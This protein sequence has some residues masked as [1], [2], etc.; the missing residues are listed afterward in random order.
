MIQ[1]IQ[2]YQG[3][4][5]SNEITIQQLLAQTSGIPDYYDEKAKDGKT[6]FD[7]FLA[8]PTRIWSVDEEIARA[9]DEMTPGFKPGEKAFYSDTNYQLLGKIIEARTGK[10]LEVVFNELL[11]QPLGLKHTWLVG[12]SQP[13]EK[14]SAGV[15]QVFY[16]EVN[17]T[18]IR[19]TTAYWADGGIVATPE[20]CVTFLKALNQGRIIRKDSLEKMHQWIRLA[21]PGMPFD[22]GFGTMKFEIPSFINR[23]A[24]VPPVWGATGS[25][26]SF[27][28]YAE[29]LDLYMAG[30][31][32]Q[33][34]D[35]ITPIVLMIKV[36]KAFQKQY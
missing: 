17:I 11:F 19:S 12:R 31:T 13:L 8:D 3:H 21:N 23:I 24:K 14:P 29:D 1:G 16:K 36:M 30:T 28:Y 4:D 2:V 33:V 20:D 7:L 5:Y 15:A 32:N 10:P 9:R 26:G 35:K 22:Y 34:D 18:G 27:L 25:T 6:I